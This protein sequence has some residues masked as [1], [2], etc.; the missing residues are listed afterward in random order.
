MI[1]SI[2]IQYKT[3]GKNLLQKGVKIKNPRT[4]VNCI[5]GRTAIFEYDLQKDFYPIITLRKSPYKMPIAELVGYWQGLT[6]ANDFAKLGAK[7]WFANSNKNVSWLNNPNRKGEND[8]GYVYG[9]VGHNFGGINQFKKVYDN[10]SNGIDDRG[11]I[12]TY[13]KPDEFPKGCLRPCMHTFKFNLIGDILDVTIN[14][15]SCD[16][17]LGLV[18]NVQQAYMTLL[19]MARITGNKAGKVTH[20]IDNP[21]IYENQIDTFVELI[22]RSALEC[23]PSLE[24]N[25][26]HSW[27][28]I[29]SIKTIDDISEHFVLSGYES[30]GPLEFEFTE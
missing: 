16:V 8:M 6:N 19:L 27:N 22:E 17:P 11:E 7:T 29:M 30:Q 4:G 18:A 3:L 13:W 20:I 1:N 25:G 28:D 10:L 12:I 21:H 2:D 24:I 14:Q 23:S 9:A 26:I 15:R 5:T